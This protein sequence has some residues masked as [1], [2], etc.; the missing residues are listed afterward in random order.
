M[1]RERAI[2]D[3][4]ERIAPLIQDFHD[5][6]GLHLREHS[7]ELERIIKGAIDGLGEKMEEQGKEYVSYLYFSILKTDLLC[8]NYRFLLHA[9]NL[10]W[11]LDDEVIEVYADMGDLMQPFDRLWEA[12]EKE[13][14]GYMGAVNRYDIQHIMFRELRKV[15]AAIAHILRYRFRSWKEKDLFEKVTLSPFWYMKWGEYRDQTEFILYTDQTPKGQ[16]VWEEEIKKVSYQPE[17]LVFSYWYQGDY[18]GTAIQE[19]DMRFLVFEE[20]KLSD[21]GF[22]RC[23]LEGARFTDT[24]L[25]NCK[26]EDCDLSGADLSSCTFHDVSFSGS[27]M[28]DTLLPAESIPFLDLSPE[29][30]QAVLLRRDKG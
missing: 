8:R 13:N 10:R 20:S 14:Y 12:L 28:T 9:M 4:Q 19:A 7:E 2:K 18:R 11:Y 23:N 6:M 16:E 29:Q 24:S 26:F 22:T 25:D 3:Y 17:A 30:L 27:E 21:L 5:K 15:D 1:D